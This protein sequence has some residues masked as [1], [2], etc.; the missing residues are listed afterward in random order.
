MNVMKLTQPCDNKESAA[1][2]PP[3]TYKGVAENLLRLRKRR[4]LLNY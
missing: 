2:S 3:S 1:V 4:I